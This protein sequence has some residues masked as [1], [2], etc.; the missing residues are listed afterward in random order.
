MNEKFLSVSPIRANWAKIS[1]SEYCLLSDSYPK[2]EHF[3]QL[4]EE[5]DPYDL[6]LNSFARDKLGICGG[7]QCCCTNYSC[8]INDGF[9]AEKQHGCI[10]SSI[11]SKNWILH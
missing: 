4:R 3:K 2:L 10:R 9:I 11:T 5:L 8:Q 7:D 6:F 1:L